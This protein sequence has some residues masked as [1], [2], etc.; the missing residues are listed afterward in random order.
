[1]QVRERERDRVVREKELIEKAE[2][3]VSEKK[4]EMEI[5]VHLTVKLRRI[6]NPRGEDGNFYCK[7][8]KKGK[9]RGRKRKNG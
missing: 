5:E 2:S 6:G 4:K 9:K 7:K 8:R 1:M 3:R